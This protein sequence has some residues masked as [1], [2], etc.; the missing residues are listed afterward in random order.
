M[1]GTDVKQGGKALLNFS[2]QEFKDMNSPDFVL[3]FIIVA[4]IWQSCWY[5][6]VGKNIQSWNEVPL[7]SLP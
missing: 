1:D 3:W 4:Y 2:A 5:Y 7:A 6:L